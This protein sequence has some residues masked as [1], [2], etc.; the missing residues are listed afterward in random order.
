MLSTHLN[1]LHEVAIFYRSGTLPH[2]SPS[3]A[4]PNN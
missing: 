3:P 4:Y 1:R 2:E